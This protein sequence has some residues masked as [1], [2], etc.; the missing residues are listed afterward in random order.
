[1]TDE[2]NGW[3]GATETRVSDL[4]RRMVVVETHPF[5]CPQLKVVSDHEDRIR[6]LENIRWQIAGIV[7]VAQ[8]LG[9]S[10]ILG[11]IKGWLK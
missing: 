10:A 7:V 8:A 3:R 6:K 5:V 2:N 1:M 4:E 9:V 11:A